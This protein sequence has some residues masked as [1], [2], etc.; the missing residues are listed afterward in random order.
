MNPIEF[1]INTLMELS[2]ATEFLKQ[3]QEVFLEYS[4][5][6]LSSDQLDDNLKMHPHQRHGILWHLDCELHCTSWT[7]Q[8]TVVIISISLCKGHDG[9]YIRFSPYAYAYAC[10]LAPNF[11]I[12]SLYMFWAQILDL[13][14]HAGCAGEFSF[15][16]CN[17]TM[18]KKFYD[19]RKKYDF[20]DKIL[21]N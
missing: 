3:K 15:F 17:V 19:R 4:W 6:G 16:M 5:C 1:C 2:N 8:Y 18:Y 9:R 13:F 7:P 12:L 14:F 11:D 20:R 10:F 21:T